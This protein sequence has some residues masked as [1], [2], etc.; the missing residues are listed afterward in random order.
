MIN[1]HKSLAS[2]FP[3]V[4]RETRS[5][6]VGEFFSPI[7]QLARLIPSYDFL[8]FC[9]S[10]SFNHAAALGFSR[11]LD[12]ISPPLAPFT[13]NVCPLSVLSPVTSSGIYFRLDVFRYLRST[14]CRFRQ[15]ERCTIAALFF[16]FITLWI[17]LK[18]KGY[19]K[20]HPFWA[21]LKIV[22]SKKGC[23]ILQS[24]VVVLSPDG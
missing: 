21:P 11:Q 3:T 1:S 10:H 22:V 8:H 19:N 4:I 17:I 2:G 16:V 18:K 9:R 7:A 14:E 13:R 12:G 6:P 20:G 23:N 5:L 24:F 15:L